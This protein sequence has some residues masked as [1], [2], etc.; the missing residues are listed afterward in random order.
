MAEKT[1]TYSVSIKGLGEE[2]ID[3]KSPV[4]AICK[5]LHCKEGKSISVTAVNT[6]GLANVIVISLGLRKATHY[7][8]LEFIAD[9][10]DSNIRMR[11]ML[12]K[13]NIA[14]ILRF[15]IAQFDEENHVIKLMNSKDDYLLFEFNKINTRATVSTAGR[16]ATFDY[17]DMLGLIVWYLNKSN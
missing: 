4:E 10:A 8:K 16:T 1:R 12:K 7:Y 15:N 13:R 3:A 9:K 5:L 11:D 6:K 17:D 2:K 14:S